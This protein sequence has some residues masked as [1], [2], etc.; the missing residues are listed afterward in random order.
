[1][2]REIK[3]LSGSPG[4]LP[5]YLRAAA[6]MIPGASLLPFVAGRGDDVPDLELR[7]SSV[8]I[9]R[10]HLAAY[11]RVCGFR[12]RDQLPA[13]YPHVIAFPLHM[14]LMTDSSFPFPAVGLVHIANRITVHRPLLASEE[15]DVRVRPTKIEPHP[16]GRQFSIQTEVRVKRKL[17]WEGESTMLRRGGGSSENGRGDDFG[18]P[19]EGHAVWRLSGDLGRRYAGVSGDRN[20]IH[21]HPLSAKL[22]GFPR[23]IAHGM[24][25]KARSVAAVEARLPDAY[26]VDVGFRKPILLPGSVAFGA[27]GDRF[28]VTGAREPDRV[29]LI[30]RIER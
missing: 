17:V 7:L 1:M 18:S 4:T 23:A 14:K 20:P 16:K 24:W 6:P 5:T 29:H 3:E 15:L 2:A 19:P 11:S 30:G 28:A 8:G 26:T 22:F 9:D 25:T 21:M 12:L 10:D 27:E 13:T